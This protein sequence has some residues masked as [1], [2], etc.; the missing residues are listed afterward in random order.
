[1]STH[2]I[3]NIHD[4]MDGHDALEAEDIGYD[5]PSTCNKDPIKWYYLLRLSEAGCS[6]VR[7]KRN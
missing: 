3:A 1:M 2:N 7:R 4:I 6:L 5:G